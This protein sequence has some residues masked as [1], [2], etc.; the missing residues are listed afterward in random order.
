M[1][2]ALLAISPAGR[3]CEVMRWRIADSDVENVHASARTLTADVG[4]LRLESDGL[5]ATGV[6]SFEGVWDVERLD[7]CHVGTLLAARLTGAWISAH[8]PGNSRLLHG[9][10]H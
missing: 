1:I 4:E 3:R 2:F 6:N 5:S 9:R 8:R 7:H 10:A